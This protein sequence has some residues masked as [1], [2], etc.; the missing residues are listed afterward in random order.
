MYVNL[1]LNKT[2]GKNEDCLLI[3]SYKKKPHFVSLISNFYLLLLE[4]PRVS[5]KPLKAL[6]TEEIMVPIPHM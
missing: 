5:L 6:S 3:T 2:G 1:F 4:V